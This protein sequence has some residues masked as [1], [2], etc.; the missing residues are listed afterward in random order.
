M[1]DARARELLAEH[2][3]RVESALAGADDAAMA[4]EDREDDD[5]HERGVDEGLIEQ[6]RVELEAID[7]AEQ[8]LAAGTYGRSIESGEPI[9]DARLEVLPWAELTTEE[10]ARSGA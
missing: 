10:Q 1:D 2:R 3:A 7:R 4:P 5:L 6:L 9:P 8:R